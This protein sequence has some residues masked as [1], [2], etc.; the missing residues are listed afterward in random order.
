MH[1][2]AQ[3]NGFAQTNGQA[4]RILIAVPI[5]NEERY[6]GRVLEQLAGY[7]H[8]KLFVDDGS[9]DATLDI[10]AHA[11]AGGQITLLRHASNRGYGQSLI[12]A[13]T[14]ARTSGYEWVITMDC[15]EQHDPAHIPCFV[16]E[17][18]RDDA[19]IISGSRYL[20]PQRL[21]GD[22]CYGE[23]YSGD[24]LPPA[25]RRAVNL[26]VTATLNKL[27]NWNLTDSFCGFKAHRVAP[28]A[29]LKLTE[30]GYAFPLQLWP[31]AQSAGLRIREI[32]IRLIYNDVDRSFGHDVRAGDLDNARVRLGLYL[33]VLRQ[34]LCE[35]NLPKLREAKLD[36]LEMLPRSIPNPLRQTLR[37]SFEAAAALP[38]P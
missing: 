28:T 17:I 2:Q 20:R 22:D 4:R 31:R 12:D 14:F 26:I 23:G 6:V 38:C 1:Y 3:T 24:D 25:E 7:P 15:D 35:S 13:F 9:T 34:E 30:P 16:D 21:T 37:E 27:F 29:G 10:L 11:A 19:D 36:V 32:P 18:N 33:D 5:F 8:D